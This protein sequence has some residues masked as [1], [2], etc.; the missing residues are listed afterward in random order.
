MALHR[1]RQAEQN[2]YVEGFNC[3]MRDEMLNE[4]LF[5]SMDHARVQIAAWVEDYDVPPAGPAVI[6]RVHRFDI[7]AVPP[8]QARRVGRFHFAGTPGALVPVF[9]SPGMSAV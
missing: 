8:A 7:R 1:A 2:G 9:G 5:L 6:T 4:T 3:R